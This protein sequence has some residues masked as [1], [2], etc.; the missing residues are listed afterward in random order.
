MWNLRKNMI[1]F[2]A[3]TIGMQG[4]VLVHD[5]Y[6]AIMAGEKAVLRGKSGSGKSTLLK[7]VV[8]GVE[9]LQ[10]VIRINGLAVLPE[11]I[12]QIRQEL[13]YIAQEPGLSQETAADD[14]LLPFSF[15]AHLGQEPTT[16][17]IEAVLASLLLDPAILRQKSATLSG[18]EKQRLVIARAILLNKQIFLADEIT[19]ALD[20]ES[21]Q[22]V[23]AFLLESEHTVLSISHDPEW[24]SRCN[25]VFTI[26]NGRLQEDQ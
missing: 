25:R 22:A 5:V 3:V 4:R 15:K 6:F 16:A 17:Q 20:A 14:L 19:S 21:K 13:A 1:S 23:F 24:L 8:G 2:E 11:N 10:G 7:A 26:D 9:I 18:G 12:Q